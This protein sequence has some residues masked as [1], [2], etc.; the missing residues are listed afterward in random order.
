AVHFPPQYPLAQIRNT[1]PLKLASGQTWRFVVE[2]PSQ[3]PA[4]RYQYGVEYLALHADYERDGKLHRLYADLQG[5]LREGLQ[6]ANDFAR[7]IPNYYGTPDPSE[8]S[9]P[10]SVL[11]RDLLLPLPKKSDSMLSEACIAPLR[12]KKSQPEPGKMAAVLDFEVCSPGELPLTV[13]PVKGIGVWLNG[14]KIRCVGTI[15]PQP[16]RNRVLVVHPRFEAFHI[17]LNRE[18]QSVRYLPIPTTAD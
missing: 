15:T 2:Q 18:R 11:Q 14:Q 6:G 3:N 9:L 7:I 10:T 13:T 4:P 16:G 5:K 12:R 17:V 1:C 8:L